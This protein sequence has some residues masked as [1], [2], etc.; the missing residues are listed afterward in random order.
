MNSTLHHSPSYRFRRFNRQGWAAYSSMHRQV[1][2]GHLD[3][4]IADKSRQKVHRQHNQPAETL[5]VDNPPHRHCDEAHADIL[6]TLLLSR[7]SQQ[8]RK[9]QDGQGWTISYTQG[10]DADVMSRNGSLL[11]CPC[12]T[13]SEVIKPYVTR[14]TNPSNYI[15]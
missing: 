1:T 4:D 11:L 6:L 12:R 8:D 9:P 7:P 2:I 13:R 14:Y 15:Q 3:V 10:A 5:H